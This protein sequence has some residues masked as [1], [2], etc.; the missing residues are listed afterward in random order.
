MEFPLFFSNNRVA[1]NLAL[2]ANSCLFS[3]KIAL[4]RRLISV[5]FIPKKSNLFGMYLVIAKTLSTS[6]FRQKQ[7]L[8]Q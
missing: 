5:A 6:L 3:F 2:A 4:S 8:A 1:N 7:F